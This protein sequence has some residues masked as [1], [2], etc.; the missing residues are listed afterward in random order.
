MPRC[1]PVIWMLCAALLLAVPATARAAA[2]F[3]SSV[4]IGIGGLILPYDPLPL[5]G[6]LGYFKQ[7]GLDVTVDNFQTGGSKAVQAL[8]GG[9]IDAVVGSYDHTIDLQAKG[10]NVVGIIL[11]NNLPGYV[12]FVRSDLADRIRTPQDLKGHTIGITAPGASTD[13]VIRYYLRQH[14]VNPS[15]VR[16]LAVGGGTP[17]L[18]ALQNKNID[19]LIAFDPIATLITRRKLGKIMFDARTVAGTEAA[20]GGD[21]PFTCV[22]VTRPFLA[23]NPETVQHLVN[24]FSA[25][26]GWMQKATPE[27]IVDTL[28]DDAKADDRSLNVEMMR[29]SREMFSATGLFQPEAAKVTLSVLSDGLPALRDSHIDLA[30]TYTN[31]FVRAS[32][33]QAK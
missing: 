5:A 19:A 15:D 1:G 20:L 23:A 14:G 24:A 33:A 32:V 31:R 13:M 26:L 6:Q 27:Q 28:P 8:I 12:F 7:Q 17:A 3:K 25:T 22:F 2:P 4:S 21:Y 18:L 10:K 9:S 29:D 16:Y 30:K 11:L